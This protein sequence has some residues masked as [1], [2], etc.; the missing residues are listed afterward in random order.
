MAKFADDQYG[1]YADIEGGIVLGWD[2][3]KKSQN[4]A[5]VIYEWSLISHRL[6]WPDFIRSCPSYHRHEA[7]RL[8]TLSF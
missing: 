8:L 7:Q 2:G 1:N 3:P 4:Y 5:D 6:W